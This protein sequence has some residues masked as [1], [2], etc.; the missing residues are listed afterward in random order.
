M[1]DTMI[2]PDKSESCNCEHVEPHR[3]IPQCNDLCLASGSKCC[4]PAYDDFIKKD[5]F[6][7]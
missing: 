6:E 2:C 7:I 4:V 1:K 3:K 5:E